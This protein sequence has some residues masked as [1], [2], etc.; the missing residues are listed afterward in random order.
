MKTFRQSPNYTK[1]DGTRKVGF[2]IHGTLGKYEGAV[3]WLCTPANKRNPVTYSSA[4][5]VIAK[6]GRCTQLVK[7]EDI[8]WHAGTVSNPSPY[9]KK[10]LQKNWLGVYKNPNSYLI[11]IECEWF[12]GEQLTEEQYQVL[13]NIIKDTGIQN[14]ILIGH[15]DIASYKSDNMQF[16]C[17]ELKKRLGLKL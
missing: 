9:A 11:G 4:H 5:Y 14:P 10:V 12:P 13:I 2:V 1:S 6:D 17:L 3:E 8:S 16:A 15:S 7:N